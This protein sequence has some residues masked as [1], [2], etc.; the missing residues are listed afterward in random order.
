MDQTGGHSADGSH[1]LKN[2][3]A[4]VEKGEK[5]PRRRRRVPAQNRGSFVN[6]VAQLIVGS[7]PRVASAG[8]WENTGAK[9]EA[10]AQ[11]HQHKDYEAQQTEQALGHL[12][13]LSHEGNDEQINQGHIAQDL[14][15]TQTF[16][17]QKPF[18]QQN[19]GAVAHANDTSAHP[20]DH[21]AEAD[22]PHKIDAMSEASKADHN[23]SLTPTPSQH[24]VRESMS[25]HAHKVAAH[26]KQAS[27]Q[28]VKHAGSIGQ[29]S[30]RLTRR[31]L[32]GLHERYRAYA[33][34]KADQRK[35]G[36]FHIGILGKQALI[37]IAVALFCVIALYNPCRT[38]YQEYRAHQRLESK[39]AQLNAYRNELET[40]V[41]NLQTPEGIE[42]AAREELGMVREGEHSARV[43]GISAEDELKMARSIKGTAP[44]SWWTTILDAIFR[45]GDTS[46][47][48]TPQ[49][50]EDAP[51][52]PAPA[53]QTDELQTSPT[54]QAG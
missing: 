10:A 35:P 27:R 5:A 44:V 37:L 36:E 30:A 1:T 11:V 15:D 18:D 2:I 8:D 51:A 12:A 49:T 53:Q 52:E 32:A 23:T 54:H 24:N 45:L 22:Y 28:A 17:Q 20:Q 9:D 50:G 41:K 13:A 38:Y 34:K 21:R 29:Q 7:M 16:D 42:D 39:Y 14:H 6:R 31:G 4:A 3:E 46:V 26:T 25:H 43:N 47:D 40:E 33:Q 19:P 48:P